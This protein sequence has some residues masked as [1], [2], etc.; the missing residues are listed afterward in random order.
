[1]SLQTRLL[2]FFIA[3]VVLPLAGASILSQRIT[4]NELERRADAQLEFGG[5]SALILY[6]SRAEAISTRITLIARDTTFSNLITQHKLPELQGWLDDR[7]GDENELDFLVVA[8]PNGSVV[9]AALG[10]P[11]FPPWVTPPTPDQVVGEPGRPRLPIIKGFVPLQ[12]GEPDAHVATLYGGFYLDRTLADDIKRSV[13]LD[14][15][16]IV[17]GRQVASTIQGSENSRQLRLSLGQTDQLQVGS[18]A[19]QGVY[20]RVTTLN[21]RIPVHVRG[22]ALSMDQSGILNVRETSRYGIFVLLG[23]AGIGSILLGFLLARVVVNPLRDLAAGAN[24]IAAG[25]YDQN[26]PLR[27]HDE[28]GQLGRAF[29]EMA[30][31]L[32]IQVAELRESREELKRALT[33]FGQTLRATHDQPTLFNVVLETS[34]DTLRAEGGTLML[35]TPTRDAL[36]T[37]V[38]RGVE[39]TD[40][41]LPIGRGI[42]GR[43]AA[44]GTPIRLPDAARSIDRAP[45]EPDF[46]TVLSVPIF[47]QERVIAV[48]SVYDRAGGGNFTESDM[49]T[50]LSLAD[51]AGVAIENV[52]LHNEAQR[53]SITDGLTGVWNKR[54]FN[55]QYPQEIDRAGRFRRPFSL[56]ML[57]LDDFKGINDTHGHQRGDAVLVEL[58]RRV[59]SV[60]R[61]IDF[62]ARYGGEEFVLIL[63]ET[64]A[65]GGLRTAEKVRQAVAERPFGEPAGLPVTLS[66]GVACFP[67]HGTDARGLLYAADMAL[68]EAKRQGKNCVVVATYPPPDAATA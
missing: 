38:A 39:A 65:D 5:T 35:M 47:S 45:Q 40:D 60:I 42:A 7:L 67:D 28:V 36:R 61:D 22:L 13:G 23:L 32:K 19:G 46:Q 29:N 1:M 8:D 10:A 54:Y 33:R 34:I 43:V 64:D 2:F 9:A 37:T 11:D 21:S 68:I 12:A 49:G 31:R 58:A 52:L 50:L 26:I 56:V 63:P 53:L 55:M 17:D 30:L 66:L 57:D 24:A 6:R 41:E 3:I 48:L 25:D 27:S 18:I 16:L 62:L 59:K 44:A 51:Q 15:T 20:A 4:V 14:A